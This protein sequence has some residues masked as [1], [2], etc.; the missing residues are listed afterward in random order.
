MS[1]NFQPLTPLRF[2]ERSA[3]VFPDKVAIV[4]GERRFTYREFADE[5]TRIARA[6]QASG[7]QPGDRVAYL[8]PNLAEMLIAHFAVPLAGGVLVALNVRLSPDEVGYIARH[9]GAKLLI[10]A[11]EL[12]GSVPSADR[13][14]DVGELIVIPD[15]GSDFAPMSNGSLPTEA[16]EALRTRGSLEPLPWTVDD[17]QTTISINY[18]SG[19]TGDPKGVSYT[20]R[21]AYLNSLGEVIHSEHSSSSI[22]LWTLPMFHCNGWCTTWGVTAIG[23]THVCLRA[24]RPDTIWRLMDEERVT[25]LNGAPAVMTSIARAPEAHP[26]DHQLT[27]TTAGA[28]PSPTMI[29]ELEALGARVIHVY[30]LTEVY[31]PYSLCEWQPDWQTLEPAERAQKLARQG[32][33]MITAERIRV[34]DTD[35]NDVPADGATIGEI[36]MRGND[37]MKGYFRDQEATELAFTGGWFHSGDL[38]VMHPDGYVELMDRAKDIVISGGENISTVE[39]ERTLLSHPAVADAAVIGIAD[40]RWGE[41]PKAFV[42]LDPE[43]TITE[44]ELIDHVRSRI[45]HYKAPDAVEF[46]TALPRNSTGKIMKYEL[47]HE[48]L[49]KQSHG[50]GR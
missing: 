22:Y 25:H 39:V 31:G 10:V 24:V 33:G 49:A 41:R 23:G 7:I 38:G 34:V 16:Y 47:R 4:C 9:S 46:R 2:L 40:D 44:Q 15:P 29:A 11:E 18:T 6:L 1:A 12:L 48:E 43:V 3:A 5:T 26:F 13:L 50:A 27:V 35:M 17:E 36:V 20:H 28:A 37:V 32:V 42:V 30:G 21:G 19:T 14:G 45:A 8:C